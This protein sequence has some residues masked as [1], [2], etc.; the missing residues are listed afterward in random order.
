MYD[1]PIER[2]SQIHFNGSIL[3]Q[4]GI[5]VFSKFY[6][7]C[8]YYVEEVFHLLE[9]IPL[10]TD[11]FQTEMELLFNY[12]GQNTIPTKRK[13]N[14]V[15]TW[16]SASIQVVGLTMQRNFILNDP[17]KCRCKKENKQ[18]TVTNTG[19][20]KCNRG[21]TGIY[22]VGPPRNRWI[23]TVDRLINV[24]YNLKKNNVRCFLFSF[25]LTCRE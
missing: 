15:S 1:C 6:F 20:E 21:R 16:S 4:R 12:L 5:S 13:T 22:T 8:Y 17:I 25:A 14:Q 9:I 3:K 11:S 23:R 19:V 7:G 24:I 18:L 2:F 10:T